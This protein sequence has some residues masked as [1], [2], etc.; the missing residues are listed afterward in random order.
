M[1]KN[2]QITLIIIAISFGLI[3]ILFLGESF[4]KES[5]DLV[6]AV[7]IAW[8]IGRQYDKMKFYM[9][10]T[11]E[12]EDN[13]KQLIETLPESILIHNQNRMLY[14][15][16]AGENMLGAQRKSEILGRS[17]HAFIYSEDYQELA[18]RR[19]KQLLEKSILSSNVEQ[20]LLRLDGKIIFVEVSSRVII[21]EG[22]EAVLST[23]K[24]VTDKRQEAEILLQKSEKLAL[25]GQMAAGIAHE[26]RNPLTS[27]KGFIQLF[28]SKYKSDEEHFNL[29][30]S[31]LERIN[32]IVGEF[33]V[34]AKPTA[35][36]FKER[37]ITSLL[38]DVVMLINAQA[39]MNNIQIFLECESDIPHVICE[40]NQ[41][42]QVF[43]NI[44]KNAIEA[45]PNGGIID[46]KIKKKEKNRVSIYFIDQ[47]L[48]IQEDRL[49]TLGEP[50]YTTKEK[51]TGLGLMVSYKIVESH[52]GELKISS[53]V[54]RGTTVE[55]ILPIVPKGHAGK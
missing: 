34:L 2:A 12:S 46:V 27:I 10:R 18:T 39:I 17:I 9:K 30:L 47:G 52:D 37:Q 11:R 7:A 49:L 25:I 41:L 55:V 35:R 44:L 28:K 54:N 29:V 6:I 36:E 42:K 32:L 5:I 38:K 3:E 20:K 22:K 1:K 26:I 53:K 40:E 31:E 13:Y 14:V 15:N 45:M 19:L 48:G 16:K 23:V 51:G 4:K 43:V 33:L 24:D 50:F 8:F 21:F